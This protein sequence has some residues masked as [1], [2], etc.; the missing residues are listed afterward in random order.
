MY[1]V[2]GGVASRAFRVLWALEE[3]GQPYTHNA[4]G[5]QSDD[6]RALNP[7]GKVPVLLD[8]DTALT[9]SV[10]IMT[11]LADKHAH[12]TAA[13]GTIARAEQDAVTLWLIDEF[14]AALW[15]AARHGFVLPKEK[16]VDEIKPF[17]RT[18]FG[19]KVEIFETKIR[20]DFVM[21]DTMTIPDILAVHCLNW[22]VG[23]KFPLENAA[24]NAY[25]KRLRDRPAFK[26]VRALSTN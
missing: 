1:T 17:L 25:A 5:P 19:E 4:A 12:L 3:L 16:R 10:A 11:Y 14:D 21:G 20:G 7:L 22:A 18:D 15:M 9:D 8:G 26:K 13:P 23:A 2:L 24:V 6:V